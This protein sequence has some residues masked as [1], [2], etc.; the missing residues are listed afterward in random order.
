M[1]YDK[2][3]EDNF[4]NFSDKYFCK[5]FFVQTTFSAEF[6]YD[7]LTLAVKL[8]R[9]CE[10]L[11]CAFTHMKM[12]DFRKKKWKNSVRKYHLSVRVIWN[13]GLIQTKNLIRSF[14][15]LYFKTNSKKKQKNVMIV[16]LRIFNSNNPS[17]NPIHHYY[18]IIIA[19]YL[20]WT[21]IS[22]MI[23][24]NVFFEGLYI[25]VLF[26]MWIVYIYLLRMDYFEVKNLW[27][28]WWHCF[29]RWFV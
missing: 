21:I 22:T 6:H 26:R 16:E 1:I 12:V 19:N 18:F 28:H 14:T 8:S 2:R 7:L 29:Q 3:T 20:Q 5:L 13:F 4:S 10:Y 11:A 15:S 23:K 24:I 17:N 25:V 27:M 9:R